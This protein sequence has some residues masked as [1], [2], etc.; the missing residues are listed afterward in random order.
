MAS[1]MHGRV[2]ELGSIALLDASAERPT[3]SLIK[4]QLDATPW[5]PLCLLADADAGMRATRRLVRTCVVFRLD[6]DGGAAILRAVGA[7]PRPTATDLV[8]WLTRR[9]R[10]APLARTLAELFTRPALR[11]IEVSHLPYIV[12]EQ[13]RQLG[14]WGAIEWQRAA[15]L[16]DLA[17]DRS[18][19]SRTV[20]GREAT[21]DDARRW[22]HDLLGVSEREF[23]ERYGWEWVLEASL[24][25]SGF[26]DRNEQGARAL[27]SYRFAA[28]WM[29]G[30][31]DARVGRRRATA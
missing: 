10:Q 20:A 18:M 19:L 3:T 27:D 29:M 8:E 16:A 7:R 21:F 25:R 15:V 24:R 28:P 14:D 4:E 2:P 31:G 11:R 22:M 12:R 26:F 1:R 17:A 23:H 9:T 30:G 6:D 13:L 5:C